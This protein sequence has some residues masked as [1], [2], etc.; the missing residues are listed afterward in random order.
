MTSEG[1]G[2]DGERNEV[3][4]LLAHTHWD[5]EWYLPA[6][7]FRQRL[8]GLID[9]LLDAADPATPF[10]LDG[11][12]IVL[13]DYLDVRPE[14]RDALSQALR[15]RA[16][17]AGPWYVL[18]DELIPSAEAL[19]RNLLAGR[20]TLRRFGAQPP[21]VLYSPDAFGHPAALPAIARG[22]G[23]EVIIVWRGYGGPRWPAG[24]TVRWQS[25]DGTTV[26]LFHLPPDGYELGSNLPADA[27]AAAER[28]RAIHAVLAPRSRTGLLLVQN[29]ADHHARQAAQSAAIA[30]LAAAAAPVPV[31]RLTLGGF[32]AELLGRSADPALPLVRGELRDSYGYAWALQG[33]FAS[34]AR[35]KR[36]NASTER[37][38]ARDAEPWAAL[39]ARRAGSRAHLTRAAWRSVLLSHPHDTLCGTSTD[40]VARAMDARLDDATTQ[41]VGIRDDAVLDLIGHDEVTARVRKADWRSL[42]LVR[43]RAAR[44]RGG[45]AE[46]EIESFLA[47][48]A[49]GPGSAPPQRVRHVVAP[50]LMHGGVPVQ[51]LATRRT[52]RRTE[53]PRHYPDNDLVEVRRV[54]AWLPPIAGYAVAPLPLDE[55]KGT[56]T[57]ALPTVSAGSEQLD[58]GML[59]VQLEV[60]GTISVAASDASWT[61]AKAIA[62]EDVGDRG[63]L[64]THSGFGTVRIEN[65]FLRARLVHSGPLRGEIE[66][67]W[68]IVVASA[69]DRRLAGA[70]KEVSGAGFVD[71]RIRLRLDAGTPFLHLHLDGINGA[72]NH[73]LRLRLR[74]GIANPAVHADA[75]FGPVRR[76]P[77]VV[78]DEERRIEAPPPTA[79]LHRYVSLFDATRGAT[80]YSDGLA[81]YDADAAGDVAV[82]L[83]RSVGDLS[84][85]DLPERPGHAG[86]P[87]ATPEA[88]MLGP[89]GAEV[90][91]FLHGPRSSE[92]VDRIERTADDVLLPLVGSTLRSA[93]ADYPRT[94]GLELNGRGLAFSAAKE[95]EDGD[96]LVLRCVNL[97]DD[98]VNGTWQLPFEPRE[99]NLARLDETPLGAAELSGRSVS[100]V[101][102]PRAVVTVIVK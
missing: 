48:V 61:I 7:R 6:G 40:E 50:R 91:L 75:A 68:R 86:W 63:D 92:T 2:E 90:A 53:S 94:A 27:S 64:Y 88:Q 22:F 99:A 87:V 29:G 34:R 82:T 55:G 80:V 84:R 31:R 81:E 97:T 52:N 59:R 78:S 47:D 102:Q 44:A 37:L 33:T 8:V 4:C 35:Q 66:T 3:V 13:D 10:L 58:N 39:A 12:A 77:V 62:I 54:V 100:F 95:S 14:R 21:P 36:R 30:A 11:Q 25:P 69:A 71:L 98:R 56:A 57:L 79:P 23:L 28:W 65:R 42:M 46:L 73:R 16:L 43:N 67:R 85:N 1:T 20:A 18:A 74:T 101:A 70:R 49:V 15:T 60:D 26:L 38:L 72:T 24:D 93:I 83:V 32:A 45:I 17:E 89:F 41:A 19:V 96:W 9:E 51:L 5:R 76:E